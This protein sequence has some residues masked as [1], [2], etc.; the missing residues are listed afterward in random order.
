MLMTTHLRI[1][2]TSARERA[3]LFP[4]ARQEGSPGTL[5]R[6][7]EDPINACVVL[8]IKVLNI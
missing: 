2:Y 8:V 7:L 4:V 6:L 3:A 5:Y 1:A